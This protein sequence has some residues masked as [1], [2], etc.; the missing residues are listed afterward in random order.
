MLLEQ[1]YKGFIHDTNISMIII[2][3][4]MTED[5]NYKINLKKLKDYQSFE[6]RNTKTIPDLDYSDAQEI[7]INPTFL[8]QFLKLLNKKD[9]NITLEVKKDYPLRIKSKLFTFILAHIQE[10]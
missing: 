7:K 9:D 5:E 4:F 10:N 3:K 1:N 2:P 8:I 6:D